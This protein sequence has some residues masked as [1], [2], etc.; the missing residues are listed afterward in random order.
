LAFGCAAL[1]NQN[2]VSFSYFG[3]AAGRTW[4]IFAKWLVV[5]DTQASSAAMAFVARILVAVIGLT[6]VLLSTA[7][8]ADAPKQRRGS[9][10]NAS[11]SEGRPVHL[12]VRSSAEIKQTFTYSPYPAVP[13]EL[14]GY[15]GSQVGGT[16]T[17]RLT[18]DAQGAVTQVT[19]L[20]G[21]TVNAI[22]D[23][24]FSNVKGNAVPA[25]DKVMVQALMRW[26][27]KPGTMRV[28]DI[29]WSFGTRPWVNYGKS[30]V[31]Q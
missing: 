9:S 25:L 17:Y 2:A 7:Y 3:L 31:S 11:R 18:V 23:E 19:I 10:G 30:K 12:V 29:Y 4:T 15:A 24:R 21:F 28:V 13:D 1:G 16:G 5:I 6:N 22:Y 14:E 27:A 20:K 8:S 26:R